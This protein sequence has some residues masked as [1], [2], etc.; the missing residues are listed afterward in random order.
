MLLVS[1][2]LLFAGC[3]LAPQKIDDGGVIVIDGGGSDASAAI[4]ALVMP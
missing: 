2:S 1:A 4:A 3:I